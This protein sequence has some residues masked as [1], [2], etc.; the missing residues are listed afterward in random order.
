MHDVKPNCFYRETANL[1]ILYDQ[2]RGTLAGVLVTSIFE[3]S[4]R[5]LW[6]G[7]TGALNRIDLKTGQDDVVAASAAKDDVLSIIEDRSGTLLAGTYHDGLQRVDRKTGLLHTL[8]ARP[9]TAIE[10]V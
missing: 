4:D 7:S 8:R 5:I 9:R 6:I 2:Q 1:R 10:S 3:D